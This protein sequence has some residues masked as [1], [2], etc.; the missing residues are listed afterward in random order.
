MISNILF[1]AVGGIAFG[2]M[3]LLGRRARAII[4]WSQREPGPKERVEF[5]LPLFCAIGLVVGW[6]LYSPYVVIQQCHADAKPVLSCLISN[7]SKSQ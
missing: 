6:M 7:G 3:Y 4:A 5:Y 2:L 1:A